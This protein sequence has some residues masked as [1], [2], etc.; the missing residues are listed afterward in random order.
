M[1]AYSRCIATRY[2]SKMT[3]HKSKPIKTQKKALDFGYKAISYKDSIVLYSYQ[4]QID[5]YK[6]RDYVENIILLSEKQAEIIPK[7]YN[8]NHLYESIKKQ[9]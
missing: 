5:L 7:F 2:L 1:L 4:S 3:R 6:S 9:L 8:Q